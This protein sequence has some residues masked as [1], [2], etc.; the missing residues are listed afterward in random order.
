MNTC[1][2]WLSMASPWI[3]RSLIVLVCGVTWTLK[4]FSMAPMD[5]RLWLAVQMAHILRVMS[6]IFS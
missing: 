5:A 3:K 4:A 6:G 1:N 2:A